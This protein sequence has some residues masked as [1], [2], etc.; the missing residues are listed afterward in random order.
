MT[1]AEYVM[2]ERLMDRMRRALTWHVRRCQACQ[3]IDR[4]YLRPG[5]DD[6]YAYCYIGLGYVGAKGSLAAILMEANARLTA[7]GWYGKP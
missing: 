4:R 3:K 2:I 6:E 1:K 7:P 5:T